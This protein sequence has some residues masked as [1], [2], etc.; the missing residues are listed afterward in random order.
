MRCPIC[1]KELSSMDRQHHIKA[2][3]HEY[4]Y[5]SRK[6]VSAS[7]LA[8]LSNFIFFILFF[9][10]KAENSTLAASIILVLVVVDAAI[11]TY[12]VRK[13]KGLVSKY[14]EVSVGKMGTKIATQG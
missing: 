11:A 1:G 14:A 9:S 7:Y 2:K 13:L 8:I 10:F 12:L 5:E 6:W 4:F 3:H